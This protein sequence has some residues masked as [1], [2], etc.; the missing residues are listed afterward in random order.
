[1]TNFQGQ[2][3]SSPLSW[4]TPERAL[5]L[6]PLLINFGFAV[7]ILLLLVAPMWRLTRERQEVVEGGG[8]VV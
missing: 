4:L 3:S 7:V 1:M 6:L 2:R 8:G 5:L